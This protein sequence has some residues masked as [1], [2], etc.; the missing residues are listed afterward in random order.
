MKNLIRFFA[1][2]IFLLSLAS[3]SDNDSDSDPNI[4]TFN[5]TLTGASEVP[6][7]NS[8]ATGTA[9][10]TF[11]KTTKIFSITVTHNIASPTNGHIHMGALGVNGSPV[12]PFTSFTSP[13]NFTSIALTVAQESDLMAN[14]YYVN[15][16]TAAFPGGELRGQLIK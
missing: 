1:I 14:L 10:L 12:F 11:N 8:T 3:C 15:I 9:T 13:I 16:H 5:A 6:A 4:T 7:N 2:S